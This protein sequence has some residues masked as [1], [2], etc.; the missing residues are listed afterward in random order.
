MDDTAANA[1]RACDPTDLLTMCVSK[2]VFTSDKDC[3]YMFSCVFNGTIAMGRKG[4]N[5][6]SALHT[7]QQRKTSAWEIRL[8]TSRR[9]CGC[10]RSADSGKI[11]D[12]GEMIPQ[13]RVSERVVKQI[14]SISAVL[15][16]LSLSRPV[17]VAPPR[18]LAR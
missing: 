14:A 10:A 17:R 11:N 5:P 15:S 1:L 2:M 16:R 3:F 8:R 12:M 4:Q 13:E 18:R 7:G 9:D 6:V